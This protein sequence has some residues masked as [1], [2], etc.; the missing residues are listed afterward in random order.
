MMTTVPGRKAVYMEGI[1][2]LI[3]SITA[4]IEGL[5]LVI[6]RDPYTLYDPLGP[7]W[8]FLAVGV[9]LLIVASAYVITHYKNPPP[10]EMEPVEKRM[11]IKLMST[12]AACAIYMVLIT[13]VGYLPAT[14]IFFVM[15][16]RIEGIKSW[17]RVAILSLVISGLYWVVF[18]KYC[19]MIFPVGMIFR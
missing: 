5:R 9:C 15:E 18:V 14:V 2:L 7:G 10:A 4:V 17:V 12:M 19:S 1:L 3:I 8:Y 16:F 6:Y 13:I 11:K